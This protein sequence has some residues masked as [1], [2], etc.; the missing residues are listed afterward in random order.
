MFDVKSIKVPLPPEDPDKILFR[1]FTS[2]LLDGESQ[3]D[4]M[5]HKTSNAKYPM[6][7]YLNANE[8]VANALRGGPTSAGFALRLITPLFVPDYPLVLV[9]SILCRG[10]VCVGVDHKLNVEFLET[11]IQSDK[12][13]YLVALN[14][15]G[16]SEDGA[17]FFED[18]KTYE[19]DISNEQREVAKQYLEVMKK[20]TTD[21]INKAY[22]VYAKEKRHRAGYGSLLAKMAEKLGTNME[23]LSLIGVEPFMSSKN[24]GTSTS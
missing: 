14:Y 2:D 16:Y 13:L 1:I 20:T 19:L 6:L 11:F 24:E 17:L 7:V 9:R 5:T 10:T 23:S 8:L 21:K 22:D 4:V 18:V 12:L 15:L 3:V